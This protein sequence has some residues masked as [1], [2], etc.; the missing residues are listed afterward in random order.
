MSELLKTLERL[1]AEGERLLPHGTNMFE[2]YNGKMQP[3]YVAWRLQSLEALASAGS[4]AKPALADIE[5]DKKSPYFFESSVSNLLGALKGIHAI[6]KNKKGAPESLALHARKNENSNLVF[7]VHGRDETLLHQT[8]RFLE[9]LQLKPIILFEQ[10]GKGK[11][12]IEKIEHYGDVTFAIVLFTPD[13]VG[14]LASKN[15]EGLPRARQNVILELGYFLGRLGREQV[16]VLYDESVELPSDYRG[17]EYIAV[18]AAGAW[19]LKLAS[20]LKAAKLSV[21]LNNAV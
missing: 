5:R 6:T 14:K 1:I 15:G 3:E 16:A 13:D 18:D 8:A 21:D 9:K 17:V 4:A 7:V 19:R 2:G 10:P 11:T 12:I 20:E